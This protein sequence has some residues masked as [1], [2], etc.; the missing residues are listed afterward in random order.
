MLF[1]GRLNPA[2]AHWEIH[3]PRSITIVDTGHGFIVLVVHSYIWLCTKPLKGRA[4]FKYTLVETCYLALF[5]PSYV[6][7]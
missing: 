7:L 2:G 1:A 4:R 5:I 6:K 3:A